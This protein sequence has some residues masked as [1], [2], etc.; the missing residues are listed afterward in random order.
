MTIISRLHKLN[1]LLRYKTKRRKKS[2]MKKISNCYKKSIKKYNKCINNTK[3]KKN[4]CEQKCW[5][6]GRNSYKRCAKTKKQKF[7]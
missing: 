1:K 7:K 6:N 2:M 3:C 5:N 4:T